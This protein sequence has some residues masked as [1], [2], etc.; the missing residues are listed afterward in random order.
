M[1][2]ILKAIV[3]RL[4]LTKESRRCKEWFSIDGDNT[5][6][7]EYPL[8]ENSI[9]FDLGGYKGQWASDIFSRYCCSVYVFEPVKAF[10]E[11]IEKRV[12]FNDKIRSFPIGLGKENKEIKIFVDKDQSSIYKTGSWIETIVLQSFEEFLETHNINS[13]DLIKINIEGAEYDLLEFIL[14]KELQI[15]LQNIQIQFHDF[16]PNAEKRMEGIQ[17]ALAMTHELTWAYPFVW[18]NWRIRDRE[19]KTSHLPSY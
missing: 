8:D 10:Y 16:I 19:K 13:I 7:Q 2:G 17:Q 12:R 3:N 11:E 18:E 4:K 6:R 1:H 9:V 14:E 15:R 5:L